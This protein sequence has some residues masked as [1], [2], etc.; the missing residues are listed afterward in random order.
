MADG[1]HP[2]ASKAGNNGPPPTLDLA[3]LEGLLARLE[4]AH[5]EGLQLR[6]AHW[7]PV[8]QVGSSFGVH[9]A[10]L[11]SFRGQCSSAQLIEGSEQLRSAH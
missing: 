4:Y 5:F 11:S 2:Q 10:L 6:S 8:V 1:P 7:D 3:Q 9:A